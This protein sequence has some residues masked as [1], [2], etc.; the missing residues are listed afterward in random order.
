MDEESRRRVVEALGVVDVA[1]LGSEGSVFDSVERIEP[2][3][4]TVGFDQVWDV[5]ELERQLADHGFPD[6]E[7]VLIGSW[8]GEGV[9][10]SSAVREVIRRR[11]GPEAM[12]SL[13]DAPED[14]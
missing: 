12:E 14:G 9:Q 10:S 6:V 13:T 3:V 4:I 2:D 5:D 8:E 1:V 7:V 11:E